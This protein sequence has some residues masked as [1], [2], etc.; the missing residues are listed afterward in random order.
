MG[1]SMDWDRFVFTMDDDRC[2][3]V[4]EA[5]IR[6]KE[7]GIIY[8]SNR[9]VNW[10]CTLNSAISNIEVDKIE[11]SKPTKLQVPGYDKLVE[12]GVLCEFAYKVK[13]TDKELVVATT[14]IETMLGDV[15]VA[16]HPDDERYKQFIG[17]E[18]EH[19]FLPD[20]KMRVV[21]DGTLVD[22]AFGTGAVKVTPAHDENDFECGR[23]N[24]LEFINIMNDDG[25]LNSNAGPYA[26]MK[27]YDVRYKVMEDLEKLGLFKGKKSNPMA[28]GICSRSKD[29]VEPLIK[30]QWYVKMT[31]ELKHFMLETVRTDEMHI[32]PEVYKNVWNG[33]VS[34]LE[35]WCISRQLWWG[36]RI[37]AY[38]I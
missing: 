22:M 19:P 2:K 4:T 5:F 36:H 37:P 7:S 33:W 27:R 18:L 25:T 15:A 32:V 8:R 10:S 3:A 34:K 9:L 16:V 14:R 31:D 24:D 17:A 13:G 23:R 38:I 1:M 6:L 30:P 11:L 29:V 28:L 21:A 12:F 20:R 26:G 35:D